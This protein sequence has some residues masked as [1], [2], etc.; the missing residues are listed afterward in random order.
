MNYPTDLQE[1]KDFMTLCSQHGHQIAASQIKE[2]PNDVIAVDQLP[3]RLSQLSHSF[4]DVKAIS[5][6]TMDFQQGKLHIVAGRRDSGK[7]TLLELIG[8]RMLV[9]MTEKQGFLFVPQQLVSLHISAEPLFFAGTLYDNL[10]YGLKEGDK[11]G[12]I[13]R[14]L[15]ICR[16]MNI[17]EK[18]LALIS[19][20]SSAYVALWNEELSYS[21]R[22]ILHIVRGLV[23]NPEVLCI[24]KPSLGMGANTLPSVMNALKIFVALRGLEQDPESFLFRRPRTCICTSSTPA[25]LEWGDLVHRPFEKGVAHQAPGTSAE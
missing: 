12:N 3:I 7:T 8:R 14:V 15:R 20:S 9:Q 23:A 24:H 21:D 4:G 11:N 6:V 17:M 13:Q 10:T 25:D 18:T 2:I 1:Q 19:D 5:N 22:H 16:G